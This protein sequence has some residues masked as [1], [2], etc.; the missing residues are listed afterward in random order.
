MVRNNRR[1]FLKQASTVTA[2]AM[3]PSGRC[4]AMADKSAELVITNGRIATM[5]DR[6]A[7]AEALA[8]RG[9]RVTAVGFGRPSRGRADGWSYRPSKQPRQKLEPR[10]NGTHPLRCRSHR[11]WSEP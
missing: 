5:A 4:W 11:R 6:P 2:A 8:V 7:R 9:G 3:L 10:R 1:T